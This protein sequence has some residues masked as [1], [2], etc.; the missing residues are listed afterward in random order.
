MGWKRTCRLKGRL[1][2]LS[3]REACWCVPANYLI[4]CTALWWLSKTDR[5]SK[6][7]NKHEN[8]FIITD[9]WLRCSE[10]T[11]G[12]VTKTSLDPHLGQYRHRMTPVSAILNMKKSLLFPAGKLL[13]LDCIAW[14]PC[15]R[16]E[17]LDQKTTNINR[18][19]SLCSDIHWQINQYHLG[20]HD[21]WGIMLSFCTL[22]H[23][24][25]DVRQNRICVLK[26]FSNNLDVSGR[27]K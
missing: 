21:I 6:T 11:I 18:T 3:R 9:P 5:R 14:N 7:H 23:A 2:L 4:H 17:Q 20:H 26:S 1:V 19:F 8:Y 16:S 22:I 24:S 15:I 10:Y 27:I 12:L 13:S 25:F